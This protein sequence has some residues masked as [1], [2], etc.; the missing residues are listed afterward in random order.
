MLQDVGRLTAHTSQA[1]GGFDPS[2][3]SLVRAY[4]NVDALADGTLSSLPDSGPHHTYDATAFS[5]PTVVSSAVGGH[6][7]ISFSTNQ[8]R[9]SLTL[10]DQ[11]KKMTLYVVSKANSVQDGTLIS[12]SLSGG[13]GCRYFNAGTGVQNFRVFSY[14]NIL[15]DTATTSAAGTW[16]LWTVQFDNTS[17]SAGKITV[18][19][20]GVQIAQSASAT[21]SAPDASFVGIGA[22]PND[23]VQQALVGSIACIIVGEGAHS[24]AEMAIVETYLKTK[25]G[26]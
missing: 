2:S 16:A 25:Y 4:Y 17:A 3:S 24:T 20:N 7:A 19:E 21:R 14:T 10:F 12:T 15:M 26:L 5:S 1:A 13:D 9:A 22:A 8:L 23:S 11:T 6:K 18:R